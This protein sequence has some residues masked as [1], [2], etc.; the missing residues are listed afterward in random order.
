MRS[1]L[2]RAA[3]VRM[4]FIVS[5]FAF[6][7]PKSSLIACSLMTFPRPQKLNIARTG[8]AN[9]SRAPSKFR[10]ILVVD[11]DLVL[12]GC[13]TPAQLAAVNGVT[14]CWESRRAHPGKRVQNSQTIGQESCTH[15]RHASVLR[16]GGTRRYPRIAPIGTYCCKL[17][18]ADKKESQCEKWQQLWTMT[19]WLF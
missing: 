4:R 6:R 19:L 5:S 18:P 14:M 13:R 7:P 9:H 15:L 17:P 16:L 2:F 11:C 1:V 8:I 10:D 3:S 12:L